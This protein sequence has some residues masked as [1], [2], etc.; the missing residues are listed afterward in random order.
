MCYRIERRGTFT[1]YSQSV[2]TALPIEID[3]RHTVR[4]SSEF[5]P[6]VV[7]QS[8]APH[9]MAH[10]L[11]PSSASICRF[12]LRSRWTEEPLHRPPKGAQRRMPTGL[13]RGTL[14]SSPC[15]AL[16]RLKTVEPRIS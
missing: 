16:R 10:V 7:V 8:H 2:T 13:P 15:P 12:G 6:T 1:F 3:D 4:V 9:P 14:S 5:E 11:H